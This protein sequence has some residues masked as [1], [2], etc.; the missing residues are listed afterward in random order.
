MSAAA[1]SSGAAPIPPLRNGDHLTCD[2]FERRYEAMPE[3]KKA[4]LIEG[5]VYVPSRVPIHHGSVHA[6]V[7]IWPGDSI[8]LP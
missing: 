4:E 6:A 2:E 8:S 1:R 5:I 3:I 7:A